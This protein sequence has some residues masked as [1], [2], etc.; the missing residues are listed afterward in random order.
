MGAVVLATTVAL[1]YVFQQ[2]E[3]VRFAYAGQ[4]QL[5]IFHE[6]LDKNTVLRYNIQK[7]GSLIR[8]GDKVSGDADFQMPDTFQMVRVQAQG[9]D[10]PAAHPSPRRTN[11]VSRILSVKDQ[12]EAKTVPVSSPRTYTRSTD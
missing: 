8:I 1:L 3:I 10:L 2:T 4:K 9:S 11:I 6:L 12:A 7:S 5:T